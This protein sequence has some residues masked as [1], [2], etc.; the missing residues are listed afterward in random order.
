MS[1]QYVYPPMEWFHIPELEVLKYIVAVVLGIV[2]CALLLRQGKDNS[3]GCVVVSMI[4]VVGIFVLVI[5]I[6]PGEIVGILL[7][8]IIGGYI[9]RN[10]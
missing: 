1:G 9:F 7:I 6:I 2:V 10:A 8:A 5:S 3:V 4:I